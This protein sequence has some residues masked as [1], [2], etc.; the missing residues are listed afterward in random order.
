[1]SYFERQVFLT[2]TQTSP[3]LWLPSVH[4][5]FCSAL[6][7]GTGLAGCSIQFL[8][9]FAGAG[10]AGAGAQVSTVFFH[11]GHMYNFVVVHAGAR[12]V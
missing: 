9:C 6:Q 11:C 5:S 12:S 2:P 3:A 1:M 4:Q 8:A 10:K 7:T